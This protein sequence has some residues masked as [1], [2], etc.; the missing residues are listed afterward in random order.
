MKRKI[1]AASLIL[2]V[3]GALSAG[4]PAAAQVIV[5]DSFTGTNG[6]SLNGRTPDGANLPG[7]TFVSPVN[8]TGARPSI[9]TSTGN[10]AASALTGFNEPTYM[11]ISGTGG[12][13]KPTRLTLSVDL[14]MNTIQGGGP[15]VRGIGL[16]FFSPAPVQFA[17]AAANFTG[18]TVQPN[19]ALELI[20]Q[21][22]PQSANTGPPPGFSAATFYTLSYS[23]DTATAG[24][25]RVVY[26]G[27]D[28]TATFAGPSAGAFTPAV[29]DLA[30]FYGDT[31]NFVDLSGRVDNFSVSG[32]PEPSTWALVSG[33]VPLLL[34]MRGR[35][36]R[37]GC[38]RTPALDC[39]SNP[40]VGVP[41]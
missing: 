11:D 26:N 33:V 13:A 10:P 4:R 22:A 7:R 15:A 24:I 21:G 16:G 27:A 19:G 3:F 39:T 29:T 35:R 8:P 36:T 2:G 6:S 5:S 32:V 41:G 38:L 20:V 34:A 31:A 17:D 25:T 1:R 14:Q 30:G 23:V 28:V 9:D 40:L 18:L 12:Y 37:R